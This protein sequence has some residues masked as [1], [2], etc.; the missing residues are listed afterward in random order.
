MILILDPIKNSLF[1]WY[2]NMSGTN[3]VAFTNKTTLFKQ[4]FR[5]FVEQDL[6]PLKSYFVSSVNFIKINPGEIRKN[7]KKIII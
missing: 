3:S 1:E 4:N 5:I 6:N 2:N 7:P